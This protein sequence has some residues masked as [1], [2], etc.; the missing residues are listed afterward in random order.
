MK[1]FYL[2]MVFFAMT[3]LPARSKALLPA[4]SFSAT[5]DT[6][7]RIVSSEAGTYG[8]EILVNNK[9]LIR[10]KNVP[11]LSGNRGFIKKAD[12]ATT[13][14]LVIQKLQKG[15]MPHQYQRCC[16]GK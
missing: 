6:S 9:L 15:I 3:I 12:A 7:Y 11:G 13:A 16:M 8:Y 14:R 10:Q 4:I 1:Q 5:G 2:V